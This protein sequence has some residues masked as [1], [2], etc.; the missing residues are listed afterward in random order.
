[1]KEKQNIVEDRKFM[2]DKANYQLKMLKANSTQIKKQIT[3]K[4]YGVLRERQEDKMKAKAWISFVVINKYFKKVQKRINV[5]RKL[6]E[7]E[8]NRQRKA[9]Q[10]QMFFLEAM[11]AKALNIKMRKIDWVPP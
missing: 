7:A 9:R 11:K 5:V 3:E 1:M 4:M 10:L 6:Y 2:L 8:L